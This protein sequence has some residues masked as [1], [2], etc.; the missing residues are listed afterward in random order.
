MRLAK[1][2]GESGALRSSAYT[3]SISASESVECKPSQPP[4]RRLN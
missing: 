3:I 1:R 2:A 4:N